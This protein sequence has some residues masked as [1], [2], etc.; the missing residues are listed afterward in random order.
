LGQLNLPAL[1]DALAEAFEVCHL[2][3][4]PVHAETL[5]VAR[6][7]VWAYDQQARCLCGNAAGCGA[8]Q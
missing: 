6:S 1:S 5:A 4:G 8:Q 2:K 7:L 3:H